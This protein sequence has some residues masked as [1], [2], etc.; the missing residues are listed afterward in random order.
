MPIHIRAAAG[1]YA[2]AV[3]VPGD[4]RRAQFI[5][6][7]VFDSGARLVNDER[8]ALGFT[9][10]YR[11]VP[12]SVQASGM[13]CASASIYYTELLQLGARRLVRVGTVG[14]LADGLRMG[15]LVVALSATPDD[16]MV[17]Q[18]TGGE[19]H[20]PTAT[21]GLVERAVSLA[22]AQQL[23]HHVGPIVSSALFYDPRDGILQRWQQRGHL[24]VEMEAAALYTL[25]AIHGA[26]TLCVATVSDLITSSGSQRIDDETLRASVEHMV[27]LGCEVAIS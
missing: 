21:F 5:A 16:G 22:R 1:A 26:E 18:L 14:G 27:R 15:D 13:G 9:G 8:G 25:G 24:A 10:T 11:G 4:P 6:E 12:L 17:T 7:H 19:A 3:L 23:R 20:A 2:P